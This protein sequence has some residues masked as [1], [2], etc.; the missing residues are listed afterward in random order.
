MNEPYPVSLA[1][2][3]CTHIILH[4]CI[5]MSLVYDTHLAFLVISPSWWLVTGV[6]QFV[7][8]SRREK[9]L[10]S[11]SFG[12]MSLRSAKDLMQLQEVPGP[13]PLNSVVQDKQGQLESECLRQLEN[14]PAIAHSQSQ[15]HSH[16]STLGLDDEE[17]SQN[18][19]QHPGP[20]PDP[21]GQVD[22]QQGAAAAGRH[23][24]TR[25]YRII[26]GNLNSHK[27]VG[28]EPES[29]HMMV[30]PM[31]QL[32]YG[33]EKF[34]VVHPSPAGPQGA[35]FLAGLAGP[36]CDFE[37]TCVWQQDSSKEGSNY[38]ALL[39]PKT[40]TEIATPPQHLRLPL[41]CTSHC[42]AFAG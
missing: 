32:D 11:T 30:Q 35:T 20:G 21:L 10:F 4:C 8:V 39:Y 25:F 37:A 7:Q 14:G 40:E 27:F 9:V 41:D 24:E 18:L 42:L 26:G 22:Q 2:L 34:V 17:D 13:A 23:C 1:T 6:F 19:I 12:A 33:E 5:H 36:L 38:R 15:S 28:L 16:H 3:H 29:F 31:L